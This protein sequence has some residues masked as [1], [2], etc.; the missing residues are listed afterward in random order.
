MMTIYGQ[1]CFIGM[2]I[3]VDDRGNCSWQPNKF[4]GNHGARFSLENDGGIGKVVISK[5]AKGANVR[6]KTNDANGTNL[7]G[8]S[9]LITVADFNGAA[10]DAAVDFIEKEHEFNS[11]NN[12]E[13][14][15][16]FYH[17]NE[18][19]AAFSDTYFFLDDITLEESLSS[20]SFTDHF[21][22]S[23]SPNPAK[24]EFHIQTSDVISQIDLFNTA[25]QNVLSKNMNFY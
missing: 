15:I 2:K 13:L 4:A 17:G 7:D 12:T 20:S 23:Y 6:M 5:Y 3:K 24:N 8:N 11:G 14:V 22:F 16:N 1:D 18:T 25:G 19:D 21:N 10:S 9:T